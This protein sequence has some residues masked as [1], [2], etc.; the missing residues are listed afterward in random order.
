MWSFT[1]TVRMNALIWMH[2]S[3]V[4]VMYMSLNIDAV[5]LLKLFRFTVAKFKE[6]LEK[7]ITTET[8]CQWGKNRS[9]KE[10]YL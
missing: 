4:S 8:S 3:S 9:P 6:F 5:L 10:D 7:K 2:I 1:H